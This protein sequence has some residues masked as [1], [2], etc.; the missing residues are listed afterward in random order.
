MLIRIRR[1]T[2]FVFKR[3]EGSDQL[4]IL[5]NNHLNRENKVIV[6]NTKC[7]AR[8][9]SVWHA[10]WLYSPAQ[11]MQIQA[12]TS[13]WPRSD[14]IWIFMVSLRLRPMVASR[15]WT[16]Q[17]FGAVEDQKIKEIRRHPSALANRMLMSK[18][19]I[20]LPRSTKRCYSWIHVLCLIWCSPKWK[21][22]SK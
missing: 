6:Y 4:Y 10:W 13:D 21:L 3:M 12:R 9:I 18:L 5:I 2:L 8:K 17:I 15:S 16:T 14:L 11:V 20:A 22:I 19:K 1:G 7:W